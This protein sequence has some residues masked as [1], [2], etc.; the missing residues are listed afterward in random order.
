MTPVTYKLVSCFTSLAR[1]N[2]SS[3]TAFFTTTPWKYADPSR[4]C[5]KAIFPLE[6]LLVSHTPIFTFSLTWCLASIILIVFTN[7]TSYFLS[8]T[9]ILIRFTASSRLSKLAA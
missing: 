8:S 9:N 1:A 2:V 7:I 6:R 5:K 3:L 4:N